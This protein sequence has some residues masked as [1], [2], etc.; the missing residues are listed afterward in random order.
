MKVLITGSRGYV[1]SRL[2]Q[3]LSKKYK[4]KIKILG[5][6]TNYYQLKKKLEDKFLIKDIRDI[7]ISNLKNIDAIVHLASLSNDPLGSLNENLTKDINH[8][9]TTKIAKF[10]KKMN[11]KRF[12]FV[13]TQSVYGISKY[14]NKTIKENDKNINPIT[15]YAKSKLKAERDILKLADDKFCVVILRPST[16]HGPSENFRSDIVLNN[17][18]ASAFTK[19]KIVINTNGKPYRPVLFI[20]DLCKIIISCLLKNKK[21]IQKKIYNVGYPGKNFNIL[22]IAKMVKK[23]FNKNPIIVLNKPSHDERSYKVNFNLLRKDFSDVINFKNKDI[24]QDIKKLKIFFKKTNFNYK[25]FVSEKTN[26]ILKLKKL[27][28]QKKIDK[29]LRFN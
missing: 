5:L 18:S 9:A 12:I 16:V 25:T 13:S 15:Q 7:K 4:N 24:I 21:I 8:K 11:V 6:D 14:K 19:N 10:A 20:D 27:L 23:V 22:Q 2:C 28:K 3:L 26:R 29:N 1:G 17:L